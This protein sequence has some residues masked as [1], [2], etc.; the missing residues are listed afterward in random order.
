[1]TCLALRLF[2]L[3]YLDV[4]WLVLTRLDLPYRV[5]SWLVLWWLV[6]SDV[7][8]S[9]LGVFCRALS[10]RVLTCL[11]LSC[12]VWTCL[13]ST[14]LG[15]PCCVL[16]CRVLPC[17]GLTLLDLSCLVL[18]GP[19][20]RCVFCFQTFA[21]FVCWISD[22]WTVGFWDFGTFGFILHS[23][24]LHSTSKCS[25]NSISLILP[26][27]LPCACREGTVPSYCVQFLQT[28]VS[29]R[30][31]WRKNG[32]RARATHHRWYHQWYHRWYHQLGNTAWTECGLVCR[33]CIVPHVAILEEPS[34][35]RFRAQC[36]C[37]TD[38]LTCG[39]V[40][41]ALSQQMV[42]THLWISLPE[43]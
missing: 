22:F 17:L 42:G 10:C 41:G 39:L 2:D 25:R 40:C 3:T 11:A 30:A 27:L 33:W 9:C 19:L 14:C 16:A 37:T 13:V 15:L 6:L 4:S 29:K 5:L 31:A 36:A 26:G 18:S 20:G 35:R 8:L 21:C 32:Y 28:A 7:V 34:W 38:V 1:M 23:W 43:T 24:C 12:F